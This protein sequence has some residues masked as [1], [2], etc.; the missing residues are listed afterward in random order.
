MVDT[1]PA[2]YQKLIRAKKKAFIRDYKSQGCMDCGE[3]RW[4]VLELDHRDPAEKHPSLRAHNMSG[5][6]KGRALHHLGWVELKEE[7][8]KCDVV[9]ANCH[10][11]R[12]AETQGW[13]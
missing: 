3:D 4:Q 1:T 12:T 5:R 7:L 8:L 13:G 2:E 11:M 6:M 9:C 10:R